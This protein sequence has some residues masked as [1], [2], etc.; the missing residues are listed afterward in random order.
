MSDAGHWRQGGLT[1]WRTHPNYHISMRQAELATFG[2]SAGL[3]D[4]RWPEFLNWLARTVPGVLGNVNNSWHWLWEFGF[5]LTRTLLTNAAASLHSVVP[6]LGMPSEYVF[7][8]IA[9]HHRDPYQPRWKDEV[10]IGGMPC[11]RES[12]ATLTFRQLAEWAPTKDA[13]RPLAIFFCRPL[14]ALRRSRSASTQPR[15]WSAWCTPWRIACC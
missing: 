7:D 6:A 12:L 2:I 3:S 8:F 13:C 15:S 11:S 14:A 9:T 4:N 5:S 1:K 10:H